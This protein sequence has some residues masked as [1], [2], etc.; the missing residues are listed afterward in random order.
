MS[1]EKTYKVS[2]T[3]M[4]PQRVSGDFTLDELLSPLKEAFYGKDHIQDQHWKKFDYIH[5]H[6][7]ITHYK[8]GRKVSGEEL[9]VIEAF[10]V[11]EGYFS[12]KV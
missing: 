7:G 4:V 1:K 5:P 12:G 3:V 11:L 6:S 8:E 9:Q 2:T 10:S